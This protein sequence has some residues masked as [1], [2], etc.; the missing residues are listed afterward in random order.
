MHVLLVTL[1]FA[2]NS[3][4]AVKSELQNDGFT[5]VYD[6]AEFKGKTFMVDDQCSDVFSF[7]NELI[8]YI[9]KYPM[10]TSGAL[11]LQV[12]INLRIVTRYN[13]T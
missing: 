12:S 2:D 13:G 6:E 3:V 11:V 1:V 7:P 5:E 8:S 10:V 9:E 4:S